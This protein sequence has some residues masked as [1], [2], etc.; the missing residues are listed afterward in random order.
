MKAI[1]FHQHGSVDE[2]KFEDV[3]RPA[4]GPQ[5]ILVKVK[6]V[7][8]NGFDPMVLRGIPG[9]KTP[10]PMIPGA[11]IAGEVA[12]LGAATDKTRWRTGQRVTI[13]PNQKR[14]GMMGETLR[15]GCCEFVSVNQA[16]VLP[17]PDAVSDVDAACLPTAYGAALRMMVTRGKVS[18]GEKVLILG[19]SGG[20]GARSARSGQ[21]ARP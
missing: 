8:L 2:L 17:V 14:I 21:P 13:V 15:G 16:Y 19:A 7:S 18:A 9:L 11:D 12:E 1:V 3:P 4:V 6:A 5:D 20:G 10:L